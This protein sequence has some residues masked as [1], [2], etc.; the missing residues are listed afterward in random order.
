MCMKQ[1]FTMGT[2]LKKK[3]LQR[4]CDSS[5]SHVCLHLAGSVKANL[6]VPILNKILINPNGPIYTYNVM[7]VDLF[8]L[9]CS[10]GLKSASFQNCSTAADFHK[11]G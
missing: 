8:F 9:W 3:T 10:V 7:V 4:N 5:Y 6:H 2:E 1:M 11:S